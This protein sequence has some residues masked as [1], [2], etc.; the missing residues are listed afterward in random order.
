MGPLWAGPLLGAE[1]YRARVGDLV[2]EIE[3]E[4]RQRLREQGRSPMGRKRILRQ[5]PHAQPSSSSRSP[6]HGS[7]PRRR[8]S[9]RKGLELRFYEFRI[10]YRQA[11]DELRAGSKNVDLPPGCFPPRLPFHA[12]GDPPVGCV[13]TT[14]A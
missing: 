8:Q 9:V 7:M 4:T 14:R 5:N 10:W 12:R 1:K 13:T 3:A 2:R 6:A 11:A